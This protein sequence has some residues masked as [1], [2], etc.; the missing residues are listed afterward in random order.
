M[1]TQ[2]KHKQET[3][4]S[5]ELYYEYAPKEAKPTKVSQAI[6]SMDIEDEAD[7]IEALAK[8]GVHN[9]SAILLLTQLMQ[10]RRN[11]L[12]FNGQYLEYAFRGK[13]K[14]R[15]V[16]RRLSAAVGFLVAVVIHTLLGK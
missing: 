10:Q 4:V 16:F 9:L 6:R 11:Y 7:A 3:V 1:A 12:S 2:T 13:I 14:K 8:E 5:D 15:A